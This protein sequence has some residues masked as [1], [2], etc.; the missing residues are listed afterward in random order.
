MPLKI[1]HRMVGKLRRTSVATTAAERF[2]SY[3][4]TVATT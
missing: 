4:R 2:P 1:T 3:G